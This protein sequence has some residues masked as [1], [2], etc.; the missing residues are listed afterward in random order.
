MWHCL[1]EVIWSSQ[2]GPMPPPTNIFHRGFLKVQ[3]LAQSHVTELRREPQPVYLLGHEDISVFLCLTFP[4]QNTDSGA[5]PQAGRGRAVLA[6]GAANRQHHVQLP[7]QGWALIPWPAMGAPGRVR[8]GGGVSPGFQEAAAACELLQ[9]DPIWWRR[10]GLVPGCSVGTLPS[11]ERP[12]ETWI[13]G[14]R[15]VHPRGRCEAVRDRQVLWTRCSSPMI[16]CSII[17]M[18]FSIFS[19]PFLY[20][21]PTSRKNTPKWQKPKFLQLPISKCPRKQDS[22]FL[23]SAI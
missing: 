19:I 5:A 18:R 22:V 14:V 12:K 7:A 1:R 13:H 23:K 10:G 16:R 17:Q 21:D 15:T 8:R 9:K 20:P 6:A 3:R 4:L 11:V 2:L